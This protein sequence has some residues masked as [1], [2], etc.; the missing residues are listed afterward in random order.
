MNNVNS[1]NNIINSIINKENIENE[2]E[3]KNEKSRKKSLSFTISEISNMNHET[4]TGLPLEDIE[5]SRRYRRPSKV[6]N[7]I[8]SDIREIA[9][10]DNQIDFNSKSQH[11]NENRCKNDKKNNKNDANVENENSNQNSSLDSSISQL[12]Q[13]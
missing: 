13:E 8:L 3:N 10:C 9:H 6:H 11:N 1:I 5:I 2:H 12:S 7:Q 4:Y